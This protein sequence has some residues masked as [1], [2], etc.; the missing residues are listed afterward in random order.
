MHY[1]ERVAPPPDSFGVYEYLN[2]FFPAAWP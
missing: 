2:R 1:Y